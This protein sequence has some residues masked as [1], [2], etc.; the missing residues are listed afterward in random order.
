[1]KLWLDDIRT[2]RGNG[3]TVV[4]S[5]NDAIATIDAFYDKIEEISLDHDI[6]DETHT[7]YD[8]AKYIEF[9][10]E[11]KGYTPPKK[12][13]CHSANPVGCKNINAVFNK[14]NKEK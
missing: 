3:W 11:V 14:Y 13:W 7:G 12:L 1:M 4:R 8:V 10:V 9:L 5:Y 2:P 6:N